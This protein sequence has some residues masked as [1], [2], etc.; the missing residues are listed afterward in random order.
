MTITL[1]A[2]IIMLVISALIGV[3]G[4]FMAHRRAPFGIIGA[5]ILGFIA[6]FLVTEVFHWGISGEPVWGGV[7]VVT[8]I[9]AA[10]VL[11]FIWS[12]FAHRH[13]Y[14]YGSRY[15]RRGSYARRPRRFW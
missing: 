11:V 7:P 14:S 2:I 4:E 1:G 6:I 9:I 10:A 12:A 13:A 3:I 15:Y 5:I 8:S